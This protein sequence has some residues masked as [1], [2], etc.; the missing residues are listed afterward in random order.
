[1]TR[2]RVYC[3]VDVSGEDY[4]RGQIIVLA[5]S[6]DDRPDLNIKIPI[7]AD[8]KPQASYLAKASWKDLKVVAHE[9]EAAEC[10]RDYLSV[11]KKNEL[12][13]VSVDDD[14]SLRHLTNLFYRSVMN[15]VLAKVNI[16]TPRLMNK[17]LGDFRSSQI[18]DRLKM[19]RAW[20]S[21]ISDLSIDE[22]SV[23]LHDFSK[24]SLIEKSVIHYFKV[25]EHTPYAL[26]SE[27][28]AHEVKYHEPNLE[29]LIKFANL[30]ELLPALDLR[31]FLLNSTEAY[32]SDE[33][34]QLKRETFE[35]IYPSSDEDFNFRY[36]GAVLTDLKI[37]V[38]PEVILD[39]I[40]ERDGL[41]LMKGVLAG[42]EAVYEHNILSKPSDSDRGKALL[43]VSNESAFNFPLPE[44]LIYSLSEIFTDVD[45][46][47]IER[48]ASHIRSKFLDSLSF[49]ST[50]KAFNASSD[51]IIVNAEKF[52]L[53][54]DQLR[55]MKTYNGHLMAMKDETD[56]EIIFKRLL[57]P[58][59]PEDKD[60]IWLDNLKKNMDNAE[61]LGPLNNPLE[62]ETPDVDS[63]GRGR[64]SKEE[65]EADPHIKHCKVCRRN[66]LNG[67]LVAGMGAECAKK[68]ISRSADIPS[69]GNMR[70]QHLSKFKELDGKFPIV[71]VK[72]PGGDLAMIDPLGPQD[73]LSKS[74]HLK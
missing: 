57:S 37:F 74:D 7:R 26:L 46:D 65:I 18:M 30:E 67:N 66:I 64:P 69:V 33:F 62:F 21:E 1:M 56:R 63:R 42:E 28:A 9:K 6:S 58:P 25:E 49:H 11:E 8:V 27:L 19:A 44:D 59:T 23:S 47:A 17:Y 3:S 32:A 73:F 51:E 72:R 45:Q 61:E 34:N 38:M 52:N 2:R 43:A 31:A 13:I 39:V 60:P 50:A 54:H 40:H 53:S 12:V 36:T 4:L 41:R 35:K 24:F 55:N 68:L 20:A 15:G 29:E 16:I 22:R 14:P 48:L 71:I 10:V 5:L 70:G